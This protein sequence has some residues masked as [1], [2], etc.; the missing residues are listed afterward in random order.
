M[1]KEWFE[2][3]RIAHSIIAVNATMLYGSLENAYHRNDH[4]IRLRNLQDE[5]GGFQTFI[6][7]A[8]HQKT[9]RDFL[10]SQNHQLR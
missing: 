8:F 4:L 10:I 3:H 1:L 5:T 2:I 9:Q 7:L 6:P